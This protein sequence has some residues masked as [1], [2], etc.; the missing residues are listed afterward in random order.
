M[1]QDSNTSR[2]IP[3][4]YINLDSHPP[5][6]AEQ[7]QGVVMPNGNLHLLFY[8]ESMKVN[9]KLSAGFKENDKGDAVLDMVD[10]YGLPEFGLIRNVVSHLI[11]SQST[12][13]SLIPWLQSKLDLIRTEPEGG[14]G[15]E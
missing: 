9:E 7:A 5:V 3:I 8:T 4:E 10:P 15:N 12:L 11:L 2:S 13:E 1:S 14:D 6:Y